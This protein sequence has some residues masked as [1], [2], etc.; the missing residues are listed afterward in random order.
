MSRDAALLRAHEAIEGCKL[1]PVTEAQE[2]WRL[3]ES[4]AE[5][6]ILLTLRWHPEQVD[7]FHPLVLSNVDADGR[8]HFFNA[9]APD[10][11]PVEGQPIDDD[12]PPRIFHAAGDESVSKDQF[13]KFFQS[14]EAVAYVP[15]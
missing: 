7:D 12:A 9:L 11:E 3:L 13:F 4:G 5:R 1:R 15:G 10:V 6:D 2:V 14:L 8:V